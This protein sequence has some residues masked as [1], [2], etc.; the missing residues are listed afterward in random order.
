MSQKIPIAVSLHQYTADITFAN[1]V[2]VQHLVSDKAKQMLDV[3]AK[4]VEEEC[5]P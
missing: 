5:I 1:S 3:V 4:F 2:Q